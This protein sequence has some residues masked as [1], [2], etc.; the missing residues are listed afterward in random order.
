MTHIHAQNLVIDFPIYNSSHRSLKKMV[1]RA[2][3][4]GRIAKDSSQHVVVRAVD[5]ISLEINPGERVALIGHNGSGKTT[6]LRCL[7]GVYAPC[8]GKLSVSGRVVP[9]LDIGL[10]MDPE[11]TGLENIFLRGLMMGIKPSSMKKNVDEIA[12]FS[13]LGNFLNMPVRTYS[14][15]MLL[16][17]AFS[18]STSFS[19]DILLMDEWLS[20]GDA[21]FSNKASKRLNEMIENSSIL[22]LA[23][24]TP[25]LIEKVCTRSITLEHGRI[26]N[27]VPIPQKM[28]DEKLGK[29][30]L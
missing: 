11:A 6:L 1:L 28:K 3:T 21:E 7:S 13:G 2:T 17:L 27:D 26:V 12:E 9:L 24:H 29:V 22:V 23:S 18:V 30:A 16:R 25:D 19:S 15:G 10:G 20:V 8:A 14:S 5:N 4:G